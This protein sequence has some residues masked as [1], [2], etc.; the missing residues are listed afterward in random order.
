MI[1][2][3]RSLLE[4]FSKIFQRKSCQRPPAIVFELL[5]RQKKP[6]FWRQNKMVVVSPIPLAQSR[7]LQFIFLPRD[8][9]GFE[10]E[11]FCKLYGRSTKI[12]GG[13]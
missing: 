10:R 13:P 1:P 11:T 5:Q 8:E 3:P 2:A 4:T 12:T 6:S 9:S 7:S